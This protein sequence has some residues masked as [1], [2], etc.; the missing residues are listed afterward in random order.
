MSP[1]LKTQTQ[2]AEL[3]VQIRG[4]VLARS[5]F[6][7]D[8]V[9]IG[10]SPENDVF[11]DNLGLSRFHATLRHHDGL[12]TLEDLASA[13][14]TFVNG[15]RVRQWNLSDGDR[16]GI[17]KFTIVFHTREP[18]ARA[19]KPAGGGRTVEVRETETPALR[20]EKSG[21]V[22]RLVLS[23][24]REVPIERDVFT[25]GGDTA[26]DLVLAGWMVP[27]AVALVTRGLAGFSIVS[28]AGPE[29]V[30]LGGKPVEW[31][32]WLEKGVVLRFGKTEAVFFV[33][34]GDGAAAPEGGEPCRP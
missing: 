11:I 21:V 31:D 5:T 20:E 33:G 2:A 19:A 22:A 26:S 18:A 29:W 23:G 14:G 28:V 8:L 15:Q 12:W 9:R 16:I 32:G 34:E 13:S 10:R 17:A 4:R 27:P 6:R 30:S 7:N 3:E 24:G 1:S 25:I